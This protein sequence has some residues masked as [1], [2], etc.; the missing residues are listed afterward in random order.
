[1]EAFNKTIERETNLALLNA[2]MS[3]ALQRA[4]RMPPLKDLIKEPK[5]TKRQTWEEQLT[6]VKMLNAAFGGKDKSAK[7]TNHK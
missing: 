6:F 3:A 2:W 5:K 1:M 4:K 7:T